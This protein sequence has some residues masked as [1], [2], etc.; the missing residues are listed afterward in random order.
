MGALNIQENMQ[1]TNEDLAACLL[2]LFFDPEDGRIRF[3]ET[4]IDF[5]ET[6]WRRI[7]E[8]SNFRS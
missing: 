3:L 1:E 8:D 7:P 6:A 5:Y 2:R 4:S